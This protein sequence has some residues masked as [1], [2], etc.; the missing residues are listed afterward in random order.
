MSD[1]GRRYAVENRIPSAWLAWL[2]RR[3]RSF[4][5]ARACAVTVGLDDR[6]G[7]EP[8]RLGCTRK[9]AGFFSRWCRQRP[10]FSVGRRHASLSSHSSNTP[11]LLSIALGGGKNHRE[12]TNKRGVHVRGIATID[13]QHGSDTVTIWL[14]KRTERYGR[15]TPMQLELTS[16][17]SLR[18]EKVRS[19]TRCCV[20]LVT[21]GS[22]L[23]GLPI[24]GEPLTVAD[25]DGLVAA[26]EAHQQSILE[27]VSAYRRRTRSANVKDPVCLRAHRQGTLQGQ[28]TALLNGP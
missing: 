1:T 19:L 25:I 4:V 8:R 22:D 14:T 7:T 13:R 27:A 12:T 21:E 11:P 10:L 28:T 23:E 5:S 20:V 17:D 26:T 6:D 9:H 16:L 15:T 24:Q 18:L 3:R 2:G